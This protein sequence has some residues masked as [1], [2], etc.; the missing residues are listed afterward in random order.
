[1]TTEHFAHGSLSDDDLLNEVVRL[2]AA[3]RTATVRLVA[4]LAEVDARRLYLG[5]GCSSLFV[6]CTRVLRL[7]EHVVYGRI[8]AVR[9]AR[10]FPMLLEALESGELTLTSICLLAPHLTDANHRDVLARAKHCTKRE[11]EEIVASLR[12]RPDVP[13][14]VRKLPD[15]T[16]AVS[17]TQQE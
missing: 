15:R 17:A 13:A 14:N 5:Q 12:P 4:A 2:A 9:A 11:V 6:Y 3:E 16:A 10:R 7:S 1:M 8:E